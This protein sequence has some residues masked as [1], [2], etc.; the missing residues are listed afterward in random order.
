MKHAYSMQTKLQMKY[1]YGMQYCTTHT[2]VRPA[3]TGDSYAWHRHTAL[4]AVLPSMHYCT[5]CT[6]AQ[7]ALLP[8]MQYCPA[9][10]TARHRH[11]ALPPCANKPL[12]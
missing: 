4:H 11:T 10:S 2:A 6:I 3:P 12:R 1:A 5:A 8:S 9:C 7:H